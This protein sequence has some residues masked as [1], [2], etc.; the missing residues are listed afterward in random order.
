MNAAA[1]ALGTF[2][3]LPSLSLAFVISGFHPWLMWE[4]VRYGGHREE[5]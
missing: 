3:A 2:S 1:V 4:K 5:V